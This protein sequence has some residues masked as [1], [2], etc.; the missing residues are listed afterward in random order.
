MLVN[1]HYKA[2]IDG[3]Y[4]SYDEQAPM[5]AMILMMT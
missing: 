1:Y 3:R 5:M 4:D 2:S